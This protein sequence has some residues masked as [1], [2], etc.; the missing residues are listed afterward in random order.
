VCLLDERDDR[1]AKAGAREASAE[2]AATTR[3]DDQ[4]IERR[5]C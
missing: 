1:A 2:R 5:A 3:H 4:P